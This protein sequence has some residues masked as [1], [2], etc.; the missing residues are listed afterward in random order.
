MTATTISRI[1]LRALLL[2]GEIAMKL[3]ELTELL[4][5]RLYEI[6]EK[7]PGAIVSADEICAEFGEKNPVNVMHAVQ[8]LENRGYVTAMIALGPSSHAGISAEGRLFVESGGRTGIIQKYQANPAQFIIISGNSASNINV[9]NANHQSI[10]HGTEVLKALDEIR[11]S[12][13]RDPNLS[14]TQRSDASEEVATVAAQVR[15]SKPDRHIVERALANLAN[16]ATIATALPVLKA[17]L[18]RLM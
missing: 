9:G 6:G 3:S 10:G 14:S 4:L 17:L 11:Q 8:A 16:I 1:G 12:I 15:K 7:Q 5:V 18:E 2:A 13:D